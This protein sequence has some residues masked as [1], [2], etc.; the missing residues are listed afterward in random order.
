MEEGR[1]EEIGCE[2]RSASMLKDGHACH[3][4]ARTCSNV[5]ENAPP[6]LQAVESRCG[7]EGGGRWK[8]RK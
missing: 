8:V 1:Q 6:V 5:M 7:A 3:G 4:A 2:I